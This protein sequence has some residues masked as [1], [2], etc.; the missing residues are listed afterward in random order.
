[1]P[2]RVRCRR[3]QTFVCTLETWRI[4]LKAWIP[5][6]CSVQVCIRRLKDPI[7]EAGGSAPKKHRDQCWKVKCVH[8]KVEG[9]EQEGWRICT[10]SQMISKMKMR[11]EV[12]QNK[13]NS[14]S[15]FAEKLPKLPRKSSCNRALLGRS[16][17]ILLQFFHTIS[18]IT[19]LIKVRLLCPEP[20]WL[21][22]A[23][24]IW[25]LSN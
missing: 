8:Q 17:E 2:T 24:P 16:A 23:F 12:S 15:S 14:Q 4:Q 1:M 21:N 11:I 13:E 7:W 9:S 25:Q 5:Q 22:W 20:C 6:Q 3:V 10:G 19:V 18:I